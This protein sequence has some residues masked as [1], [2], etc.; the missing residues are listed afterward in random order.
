MYNSFSF[1]SGYNGG[2][3]ASSVSAIKSYSS[4]SSKAQMKMGMMDLSGF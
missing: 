2:P 4:G 3:P 1:T